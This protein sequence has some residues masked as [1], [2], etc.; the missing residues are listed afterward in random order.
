MLCFQFPI[1]SKLKALA[2]AVSRLDCRR[3]STARSRLRV[4][5]RRSYSVVNTRSTQK[6][7]SAAPD[8]GNVLLVFIRAALD[9]HWFG[10]PV[11]RGL[12]G[13]VSPIREMTGGVDDLD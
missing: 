7:A 9:G 13:A 12:T 8:V 6:V 10:N 1:W 5:E 11:A 4:G 3:E 2:D